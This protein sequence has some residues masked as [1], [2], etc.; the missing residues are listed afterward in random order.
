MRRRRMVN[1]FTIGWWWEQHDQEK[2]FERMV[3]EVAEVARQE[4]WLD[5]AHWHG[6]SEDGGNRFR[7]VTA[8][9]V[10]DGEGGVTHLSARWA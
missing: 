5:R 2:S 4:G 7:R 3:N 10:V 9:T 1:S 6:A 8:Q